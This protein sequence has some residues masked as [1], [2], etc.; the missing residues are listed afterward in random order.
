MGG[1]TTMDERHVIARRAA[2]ELKNGDVVNLGIGIPTL[3][4]DYLEPDQDVVF[5]TE[6]GCIGMGPLAKPGQEDL[7]MF[8][9]GS[10]LAT[11]VPCASFFDSAMA[12]ALIRGGHIDV[13]ILGAMEADAKGNIA[14]WKVPGKKISGAGGAMDLVAGAKKLIVT[15]NHTLSVPLILIPKKELEN[16]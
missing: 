13:V 8:N 9:A 10:A 1:A 2:K 14:N 4:A 16:W 6:N 15:M 3:V 11:Y 7:D 12:F 5:Q